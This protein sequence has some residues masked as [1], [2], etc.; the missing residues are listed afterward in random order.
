MKRTHQVTTE[1]F[2]PNIA[3]I[4]VV[5]KRM[6]KRIVCFQAMDMTISS[7]ANNSAAYY[8]G[9]YTVRNEQRQFCWPT[10]VHM[11]RLCAVLAN[12]L[13]GLFEIPNSAPAVLKYR[14]LGRAPHR[15]V[16]SY[17]EFNVIVHP[18]IVDI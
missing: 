2:A 18:Y 15:K 16:H 9:S 3:V 4:H 10:V 1:R 11:G 12:V 13:T 6:W 8:L 17:S 7:S 5:W 14:W